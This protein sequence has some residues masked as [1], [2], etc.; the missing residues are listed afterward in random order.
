MFD[1]FH[2]TNNTEQTLIVNAGYYAEGTLYKTIVKDENWQANQLPPLDRDHTMEEFKNKSGQ[3]VLKRTYN[4]GEKY[5]TYYIYDDFGNL[6]YVIPP[7]VDTNDGVSPDEL[8]ELC[9]QYN[10][11]YRNRLMVNKIP[12]TI[13]GSIM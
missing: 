4:N 9:Y 2:P 8:E 12:G 1:V 11:D 13:E 7:L 10:Y 3:T 6:T 5:D